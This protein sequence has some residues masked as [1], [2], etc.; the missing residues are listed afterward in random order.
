VLEI[1]KKANRIQHERSTKPVERVSLFAK[2]G[3]DK[4]SIHIRMKYKS[5]CE[6]CLFSTLHCSY[7]LYVYPLVNRTLERYLLS[8]LSGFWA[9]SNPSSPHFQSCP[10]RLQFKFKNVCHYHF[11]VGVKKAIRLHQNLAPSRFSFRHN[12]HESTTKKL[13]TI[14]VAIEKAKAC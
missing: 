1:G 5:D 8:E 12:V 13:Q 9:L 10:L 3:N 2:G 14:F 6:Y 4:R 7:V 11:K